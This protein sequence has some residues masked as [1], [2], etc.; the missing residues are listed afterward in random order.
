MSDIYIPGVN[1][2]FNTQ[3]TIDDLMKLER[4]PRDRAADNVTKLQA[5]KTYWQDVGSRM[6]TLRDN[7]RA[8]FSYQNP[9]ND[10]IV[11]S[12]DDSVLTGTAVREA[13]EQER[14][15]VIKQTA[16]ADRFLSNPLDENYK[17][18]AGTYT[19]TVGKTVV[20]FSFRGGNLREFTDAINRRGQDKLQASVVA[21]K[22]GTLSLLLE[23]RVTGADNRLILSDA[24]ESLGMAVGMTEPSYDSRV[25]IDGTYTANAGQKAAI[26]LPNINADPNLILKFDTSTVVRPS[27]NWVV[28]QPPAGPSIPSPGSVSYGG[29]VI[30]NE[31]SAVTMPPWNPPEPPKRVDNMSVLSLS[32]SDGTSIQMPPIIDSTN[33]SSY[34]FKLS[35]LPPGKTLVSINIANNNTNRDVSLRNVQIFDPQ[36]TGGSRPL[37][38]VSTA[39]N[40]VVLMDGIEIERATNNIDDL[41]PGL[42]LNLKAPSDRPVNI[43]VEPD[44]DGIKNSI[45]TFVA[46]YNKL[47]AEINI[48]TRTDPKVIDELTYLTKDESDEYK[49]RLGA[50]QADTTLNQFRGLMQRTVTSPYPTSMD[51]DLA[52]L[53]QIGIG[54]DVGRAGASTGY[55]ASRLRGYLEIDEKALDNAIAT[56]TDAV[57]ELFGSDT[58]GDMLVDNGIAFNL[59]AMTRP[60]VET[61][62]L[63][64]LKTGTVDSRISQ[65]Q[66]RIANMDTQLT[67]KEAQLKTQY[68]QMES[69]YNR[70]ESM[71]QSLNNFSQQNSN[72]GR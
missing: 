37:N 64:T 45:I 29:I 6:S 51:R 31:P 12:S 15:F 24:A 2:R 49:N 52:L 19:F 18:D 17:V 32:F 42:T 69:A 28:P 48:L 46:N 23:S 21:V 59:D 25:N 40:A 38:A 70:M 41:I 58:N 20:S 62:G 7:A 10:R 44:R 53:S 43:Q 22:P 47:M 57:R 35:D 55:D 13:V 56:K 66:T 11:N 5:Q 33:P 8:L 39:Q 16:K 3:Q 30:E 34:Q 71:T 65:E 61:G 68:A 36:S 67:A 72:N 63:I 4:V 50:F 26:Q 27:D 9:F 60:Y 14:S 54:A 1:S